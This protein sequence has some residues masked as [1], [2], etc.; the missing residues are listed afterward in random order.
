MRFLAV[1]A[2]LFLFVS[3]PVFAQGEASKSENALS[4]ENISELIETLESESARQEFIDNLKTLIEA[5]KQQDDSEQANVS[6]TGTLGLGDEINGFVQWYK[7]FLVENNLTNSIL[8]KSALAGLALV[9]FLLLSY[10]NLRAARLSNRKL[11]AMKEK[12]HISHNRFPAYVKFVKLSIFFVLSLLFVFSM[13]VIWNLTDLSL[14]SH[15]GLQRLFGDFIEVALITFMAFV[16]WEVANGILENV[17][18]KLDKGNTRRFKTL[19]PIVQNVMLIAFMVLFAL[20]LMAE[21]GINIVPL[22]AG[23]GVVG[24]AIGFGAQTIV[25]DFLTGFTIILEDLMRVG[26]YVTLGDKSG[27]IEKITI[28]KVQLRDLSGTVYTIPYS[29]ISI[30]ENLTKDFSYYMMD[31][32][33]AYRENTDEVVEYLK[34]I[35]AEMRGDEKYKDKIMAPIDVMGVQA[36]AD[37]AVLIRARLKTKAGEQWVVGREYNRRMKHKFDEKNVEIPF[38][39]QTIYFGVD[40]DGKAPAAHIE[41]KEQIKSKS[42]AQTK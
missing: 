39:H 1:F 8:G 33:V 16:L 30:V 24:I 11:Q 40:K 29:E 20:V 13:G 34:E 5:Q 25:K 17:M 32:G 35:D 42:K 19:L 37:S 23:A 15:D 28:R 3:Q 6:V 14:F 38:P 36:F 27:T 10:F 31:V 9:V 21:L 41:L 12:Y 2:V 22:M 26:D 4:E 18:A 7:N